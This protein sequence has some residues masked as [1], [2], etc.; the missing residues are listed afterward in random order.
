[1]LGQVFGTVVSQIASWS[2]HSPVRLPG[3][4]PTPSVSKSASADG[5][6]TFLKMF[7]NSD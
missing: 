2:I 4:H 7:A 6:I 1:M 3:L 5:K